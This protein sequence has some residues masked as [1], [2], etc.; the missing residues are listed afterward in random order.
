[1]RVIEYANQAVYFNLA[2]PERW[3]KPRFGYS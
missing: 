1:M 2:V 3:F